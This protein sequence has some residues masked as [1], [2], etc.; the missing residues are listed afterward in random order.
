MTSELGS[1]LGHRGGPSAHYR[2]ASRL[3]KDLLVTS[4]LLSLPVPMAAWI[5]QSSLLRKVSHPGL[6]EA[7]GCNIPLPPHQTPSGC[8]TPS[9]TDV[10]LNAQ[11][12]PLGLWTLPLI[13]RER[14]PKSP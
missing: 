6:G 11:M 9:Q 8:N 14:V 2:G 12:T 10:L 5:L 1:H 4:F 13:N 7:A 3:Q